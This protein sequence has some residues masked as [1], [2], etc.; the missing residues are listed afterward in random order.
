LE[1]LLDEISFEASDKDGETYHVNAELVNEKL[2]ELAGNT[3]LS[4]FIL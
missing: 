3:D 1:Y 2:K 4:K